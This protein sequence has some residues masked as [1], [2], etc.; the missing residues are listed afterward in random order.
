MVSYFIR[1]ILHMI[2]ILLGV[3]FLTFALFAF[4]GEDPVILALGQHASPEAIAELRHRWGLDQQWYK[5]F[6][7]FIVQIVTFDYGESYSTGESITEIFKQGALVSLSLT[8]PPFFVGTLINLAIAM[9]IAY[10]RGSFLDRFST[11]IFIVLMSFSYLVYIIAFQYFL[12]FKADWFPVQGYEPGLKAISYLSLPWIIMIIVS[13]GGDIRFFVLYFLTRQNLIMYALLGPK[14][15]RK[16]ESF[17]HVLKNAM[18]PV[19]TNT[20]VAIPF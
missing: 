11:T 16:I 12:A 18:I 10:R 4:F 1:R 6:W 13:M 5:Q 15:L 2:P 14:V 7:N 20:V 19:L 17:V 3:A 9:I 8:A